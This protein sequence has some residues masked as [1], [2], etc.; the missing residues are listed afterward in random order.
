VPPSEILDFLNSSDIVLRVVFV[1]L[2]GVSDSYAMK[3]RVELVNGWLLDCW[4][5][6][7][8]KLRRYSFHVFQGRELIVRWDN[9]PHYPT[10]GGFP[11]HKHNG[12]KV[13]ESENMTVEKVLKELKLMM[14]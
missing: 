14:K 11:H 1:K 4:E 7:T 5:H 2:D 9:T 8:P 10:L 13:V 6:K 3:I 12:K